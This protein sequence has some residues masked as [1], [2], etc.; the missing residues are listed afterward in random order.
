MCACGD[1]HT[2]LS[3]R[4]KDKSL[5]KNVFNECCNCEDRLWFSK[6][7]MQGLGLVKIC[8]QSCIVSKCDTQTPELVYGKVC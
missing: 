3:C 8:H 7:F 1:Q 5:S 6:T 2:K 4:N